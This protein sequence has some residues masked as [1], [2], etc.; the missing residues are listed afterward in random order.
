[1][2][3]KSSNTNPPTFRRLLLFILCTSVASFPFLSGVSHADISSEEKTS[4]QTSTPTKEDLDPE[5]LRHFTLG[6]SLADEGNADLAIKEFE[7]AIRLRPDDADAYNNL[8]SVYEG[9]G[10]YDLAISQ[11]KEA[12]RLKPDFV[13]AHYNLGIAYYKKG[14]YDLA[15]SQYK[16]A[17]RIRPDYV[18]VQLGLGLAYVQKGLY[19]LAISHA[20]QALLID[21]NYKRASQLLDILHQLKRRY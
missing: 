15:I 10:L 7:E 3:S 9:K 12:I 11:Y 17:T 20:E 1:M 13:D 14:Q 5:A 19:D 2:S 4:K 21:P 18:Y 6:I 8:G 16:E